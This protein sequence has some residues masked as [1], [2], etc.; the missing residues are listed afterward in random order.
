MYPTLLSFELF[1][2]SFDFHAYTVTL[3]TAFLVGI[4]LA[5]R[6]NYTLPNPYPITPAGGIWIFVF[7]L[8]GSKIYYIIQYQSL[9]DLVHFYRIWEGG[10]VFYGGL[11][12]GILGAVIYLR[13]CKIPFNQFLPFGDLV[14]PFLP[15]AHAIAR[16]GCFLNGC[17]WGAR[18]TL[19]WGV[20][21][22]KSGYGA[23]EQQISQGLID[24]T[25]GRALPV[26]P[27]QLYEVSGLIVIHLIMRFSYKHNPHTGFTMLLYPFLYGILRFCVES[28]RG[29]SMRPFMDMTASQVVA[30]SLFLG[31]FA[32][33]LILQQTLWKRDAG[34]V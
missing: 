26:H 21:Y 3:A 34:D 2:L 4:L 29:D 25:A 14:L 18:T 30:L 19:P 28:F 12:G 7:A 13:L 33:M 5:V 22:P 6:K 9:S 8:L 17:C 20:T 32:V 23:Y 11:F 1:G 31:A 24:Y 16:V 27:S 15:L 10:L